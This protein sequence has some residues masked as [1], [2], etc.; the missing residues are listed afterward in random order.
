M[1]REIIVAV[2]TNIES[3]EFRRCYGEE[4][5]LPPEH[6]RAGSSDDV[7][8]IFAFLHELLGPIFGEKEFHDAMPK[9]MLE[10]TKKC[11]PELPFYHYTGVNERFKSGN[12]C[13]FNQ[14]SEH[15][16]RLDVVKISRRADP[17][18]F[19]VNRAIIPQRGQL[20][21]RAAHFRPAEELPPP[22][23]AP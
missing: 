5:G 6:P 18:V 9:V 10:Y 15:A 4:K 13:S 16:E 3:Q 14:P 23:P 21:V 1:T 12:L 7:E 11:D 2:T 17:G 20:T 22:P 19:V 8:G